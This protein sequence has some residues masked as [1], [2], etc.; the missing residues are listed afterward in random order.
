MA[1]LPSN[2]FLFNYN[3]KEYNPTT[4]TLPKTSGQLF[5]E[6]IVFSGTP[7]SY[8]EDYLDF[9]NSQAYYSKVYNSIS[10]NPFNRRFDKTSFTFIYKTS[11]FTNNNSSNLFC[12]RSSPL[13]YNYMVRGTVFHTQDA[14]YLSLTPNTNPQIV[15]I[16]IYPNGSAAKKVVDENGNTLQ[17]SYG[18]R[19]GWGYQST[20]ITFF[21]T[22]YSG[23]FNEP[24]NN[25]FYWMY[26]SNEAL[27]DSEILQV[28]QYNEGL[29]DNLSISKE[30]MSFSYSGG[31]DSLVVTSEENNW[32]ASTQD[33]WITISP[34]SGNTGET[35]VTITVQKA[36]SSKTGTVTFTDGNSTVEL[37]VSQIFND[38][39][40]INKLFYNGTK[41]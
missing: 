29:T 5:D 18:G 31:T 33:S 34:N 35:T 30:E 15:V 27:S 23:S 21:G 16:S 9:S 25:I 11:G 2:T 14:S 24:F 13:D 8:T 37:T 17:V 36:L 1:N 20:R 19:C 12:N 4:K 3:A 39:I 22:D 28:I 32:S 40:P 26:L 7:H 38:K 41:I 6:D 10:E